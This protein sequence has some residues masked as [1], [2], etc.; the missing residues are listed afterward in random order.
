MASADFMS[1]ALK[2]STPVFPMSVRWK[3][4]VLGSS[5]IFPTMNDAAEPSM[6]G[7]R[8][9]D[10][11]WSKALHPTL[12]TIVR[13]FRRI[14]HC[15]S[16]MGAAEIPVLNEWLAYAI[17]QLLSIAHDCMASDL[18]ECLRLSVLVYSMVEIKTFGGL[19]YMSSVVT[20]LRSRLRTGLPQIQRIAPDLSFWML[21]VGGMASK[22][23][24]SRAWF[25][26]HLAEVAE[27]LSLKEWDTALALL[28][29]FLFIYQPACPQP[30]ALWNEVKRQQ[31]LEL[32]A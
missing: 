12:R 10:S 9:F 8:F 29:G 1:A 30:E 25:V 5:D 23:R 6:V 19:P 21:F 15:L 2:I 13:L 26:A 7:G 27:Q 22:G 31:A 14:T 11:L 28:E 32:D 20:A 4:E 17:H 18:H 3:S 24:A 16:T